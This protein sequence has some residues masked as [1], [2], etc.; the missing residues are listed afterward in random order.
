MIQSMTGFATQTIII[1]QTNGQSPLH[2][3]IYLKSLNS[4]FFEINCKI[5]PNLTA[6][7]VDI[8]KQLKKCLY[9][10][11]IYVTI[12]LHNPNS[13]ISEITADHQTVSSYIKAIK[14][15]QNSAQLKGEIKIDQ[16]IRLPNVF[17]FKEIM[18]D[19]STKN[20]ILLTMDQITQELIRERNQEGVILEQDLRSRITN[21]DKLIKQVINLSSQNI[22]QKKADMIAKVEQFSQEINDENLLEGQ[23]AYMHNA[24]DKLD[25]H[26]EITRF[27]GHLKKLNSTLN[28]PELEKGKTLD[29]TLQECNRE[30]NTIAAK[31]S[32][33]EIN[34][35]AIEVKIEI[36]KMRQQVQN[37]I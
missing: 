27:C 18:L 6:L 35:I 20:Q 21:M 29:F 36:E 5:P 31:A 12:H 30:I 2:L 1:D 34:T 13:L 16:I 22:T 3:T 9:R 26:E 33:L 32:C 10:G 37:I 28:S 24:L 14:Q 15:I 4:R 19:E 17:S 23:K 11:Q 25:V 8:I 7:E